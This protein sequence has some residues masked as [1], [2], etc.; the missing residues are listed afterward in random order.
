[1]S[2]FYQASVEK[3]GFLYI[4]ILEDPIVVD[5]GVQTGKSQVGQH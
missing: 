3:V 5:L 4:F 1:V 2:S